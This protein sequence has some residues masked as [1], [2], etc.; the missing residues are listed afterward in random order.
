MVPRGWLK[1]AVEQKNWAL[2]DKLLEQDN[3]QVNDNRMFTDTWGE[4]WSMLFECVRL[5]QLTGIKILLKHGADP[6][7]QSW[8]DCLPKSPLELAQET[9]HQA[10]LEFLTGK[11]QA[12][13]E[14]DHDP[15]L[16]ELTERDHAIEAQARIAAES[17][18]VFQVD[19]L[20]KESERASK[21]RRPEG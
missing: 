18:L 19:Y 13:Y 8:G 1:R 10:M 3:S 20:D 9:S 14:R 4:W 21:R 7:L 16:P 17:G 2:L 11:T 5:K 15:E 12:T 6:N